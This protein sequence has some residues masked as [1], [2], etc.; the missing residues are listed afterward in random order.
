LLS[1]GPRPGWIARRSGLP[2]PAL[3]VSHR[4]AP[5]LEDLSYRVAR[6]AEVATDPRK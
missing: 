1:P 6:D 3:C 2:L 5:V 4:H